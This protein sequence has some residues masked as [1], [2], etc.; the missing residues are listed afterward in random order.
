MNGP[1]DLRT[2]P[3]APALGGWSAMAAH[4]RHYA[5]RLERRAART[6]DA[7]KRAAILALAKA[8]RDMAATLATFDN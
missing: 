3:Q 6:K 8:T 5:D 2:T 7:D 4:R 1:A